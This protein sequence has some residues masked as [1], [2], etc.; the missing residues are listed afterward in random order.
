MHPL[1]IGGITLVIGIGIGWSIGHSSGV[2]SGE[3]AA[4]E[5]MALNG[6]SGHSGLNSGAATGDSPTA[7][8][9]PA[10][11][12]SAPVQKPEEEK[13]VFTAE[14]DTFFKKLVAD[15]EGGAELNPMELAAR[16]QQLKS[17]GE[18]G[19]RVMADYLKTNEDMDLQGGGGGGFRAPTLRMALLNA[20][21]GEK[22]ETAKAASMYVMQTSP[23]ISEVAMAS[24]NL[25]GSWPGEYSA[26]VK[27]Q[28]KSLITALGTSTDMTEDQL[29]REG[30]SALMYISQS[31][32]TDLLPVIEGRL[33]AASGREVGGYLMTL[34]AMD[35]AT[36]AE[37]LQRMSSNPELAAKLAESG[38]SVARLDMSTTAS[39]ETA[40]NLYNK[41]APDEQEDFLEAYRGGRRGGGDGG[42][43]GGRGR[44]G[45][46]GG[47]E[48]TPEQRIASAQGSLNVLAKITP[49]T[50][51]Q[52]Q[53]HSEAIESL[54]RRIERL[55][56][57]PAPTN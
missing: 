28:M 41:M 31:K 1:L 13:K 26:Q 10:A 30:F 11:I 49:S 18:D 55:K 36:Q 45:G 5:Q 46:G 7:P 16:L 57:P 25:E 27:A 42:W 52:Q 15:L 4:A 50:P 14:A 48:Q 33:T 2:K 29:R 34:N 12:S 17:M 47:N 54:N 37:A 44:W 51:V 20:L 23:F 40:V 39:Q 6:G 35:P 19:I 9:T 43:G 53:L 3:S 22:S 56:N 8:G 21:N 24:R 38:G 32:S